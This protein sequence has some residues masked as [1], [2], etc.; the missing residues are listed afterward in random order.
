MTWRP[1][2]THAHI[3]AQTRQ[4]HV[5]PLQLASTTSTSTTETEAETLRDTAPAV[6]HVAFVFSAVVIL[7]AEPRGWRHVTL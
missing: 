2:V 1:A 3:H 5:T 6:V 4:K 7:Y